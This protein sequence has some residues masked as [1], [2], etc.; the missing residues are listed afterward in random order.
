MLNKNV[1]S[2]F[3]NG[4]SLCTNFNSFGRKFHHL[5]PAQ[6]TDPEKVLNESVEFER[7]DLG[8]WSL[9]TDKGFV[10]LMVQLFVRQIQP[11][12]LHN[13]LLARIHHGDTLNRHFKLGY[14]RRKPEVLL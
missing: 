11:C 14:F 13:N 1:L 10:Y 3:L 6:E 4:F 9:L 8:H 2:F 5:V 7:N 12:D